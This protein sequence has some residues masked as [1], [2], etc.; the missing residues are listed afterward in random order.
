MWTRPWHFVV[1]A[2][3]ILVS[4]VIS[5]IIYVNGWWGCLFATMLLNPIMTV[6]GMGE[7]LNSRLFWIG[8]NN[9]KYCISKSMHIDITKLIGS[10]GL[11]L[12]DQGGESEPA[13]LSRPQK[14]LTVSRMYNWFITE[15]HKKYELYKLIGIHQRDPRMDAVYLIGRDLHTGTPYLLREPPRYM[16]RPI[17]DCLHWNIGISNTDRLV[18][19]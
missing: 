1:I 12:L 17:E 2:N 10:F 3:C 13:I 7:S 4:A 5:L 9:G 8:L 19:V 18:E 16:R 14:Y 11:S 15:K 6:E